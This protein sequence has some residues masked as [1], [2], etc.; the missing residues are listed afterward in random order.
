MKGFFI[1]LEGPDGTGKTTQAKLLLQFLEEQG[2][3][4]IHTFEPGGTT[5]GRAIRELVLSTRWGQMAGRTELLLMAADRAQHVA[6]VIRPALAEGLIVVCERYIDSTLAYQGYGLGEDL[7]LIRQANELATG[8]LL[9]DLTIVLDVEPA[10]AQSRTAGRT[11]DRIEGRGA[12]FQA[13]VREGYRKLCAAF[14]ERMHLICAEGDVQV[15][16]RRIV[17][18]VAS[19]IGG[20]GK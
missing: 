10:T 16:H 5:I 8:G 4:G 14:P 18:L 2:R 19:R 9:P 20:Q 7:S 17:Q 1:T 13:R 3:P 6:E 12:E 15:V 11:Q